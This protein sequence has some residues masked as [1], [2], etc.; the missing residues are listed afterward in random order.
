M[1]FEQ[2]KGSLSDTAA[3]LVVAGI[4]EGEAPKKAIAKMDPRFP[5]RFARQVEL[6]CTAESFEGKPGQLVVL[7]TYEQ[8]PAKKLLICGLGKASDYRPGASRKLTANLARR[9]RDNKFYRSV[10]FVLRA[11]GDL[12]EHVQAAVEGYLLGSWSFFKYK[13]SDRDKPKS[14]IDL[15]TISGANLAARAFAEAARAGEVIA[16][17]TNFARD[18][19]A[20][21]AGYMTPTRLSQEARRIAR[22]TGLICTIMDVPQLEKLKMGALLGVARG[23]HEPPRF[24]ILKHDHPSAKKTIAVAGKGI[25]F[26]SG[27]LSLKPAQSME[28]MKYDMSGAAAVIATMQVVG[29]L[30]PKVNVLAVV[31]ATE[32]M[33]G[34]AALHPGDVVTALNGK[35]I[36]VNNTDAEGRLILADALSYVVKE[37]PDEI[38]DIATL[39][40]GIVTALGRAAAGVMGNDQRLVD[41]L[42]AAGEQAG[43]RLWQM[44][45]FDEYKDYLKSDVADLK[46][47]GSRGEAASSAGGMFLKEF[48]DGKPWAHLDI[49]GPGWVD[50][51]KDEVNKGGT[52]FGVRTLCRYLCSHGRD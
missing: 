2:E 51:E 17:A 46:N 50:R 5:A 43:E 18:L 45:L 49:A 35:T 7:P 29:L 47:A 52:A 13:S 11:D 25:T 19:I 28:H 10:C 30:K 34:G 31:A 39:T 36:E 42:I 21:P 3:D 24:I 32:N 38:V 41:R 23:A 4:F 14:K 8:L 27:G 48:V 26:D 20:E 22:E 44:P 1:D 37:N 40:G 12:R 33:P 16:C 9:L 15:V 6:A